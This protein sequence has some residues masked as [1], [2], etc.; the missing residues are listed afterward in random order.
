[1]V[2]LFRSYFHSLLLEVMECGA[3]CMSEGHGHLWMGFMHCYFDGGFEYHNCGNKL[4][5]SHRLHISDSV[6]K[7]R[8]DTSSGDGQGRRHNWGLNWDLMDL[9]VPAAGLPAHWK[10]SRLGLSAS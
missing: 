5:R 8:A 3:V 6:P 2:K 10:W 7:R 9:C 4:R 1:M